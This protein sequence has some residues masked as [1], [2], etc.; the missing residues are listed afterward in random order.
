MNRLSSI[1]TATLG[2]IAFS[3]VFAPSARASCASFDEQGAIWRL[4][5]ADRLSG[6]VGAPVARFVAD[7]SAPDGSIV[8]FW[9]VDFTADGADRPFDSAYAQ[10]H[11]D[12]TEIMN[13]SRDP[14]TQAFCL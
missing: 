1:I 6:N 4:P 3:T 11:S 8:G 7:T 9:R 10:W 12:G 5:A 13:S 14:R 2:V